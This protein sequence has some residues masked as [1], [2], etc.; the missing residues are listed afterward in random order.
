MMKIATVA[1][2]LLVLAV[3]AAAP[4]EAISTAC[5]PGGLP[6]TTTPP[7]ASKDLAHGFGA[8]LDRYHIDVWRVPCQ[9]GSGDVALLLRATPITAGPFV[10][11]VHFQI[12]QG[13]QIDVSFR[14]T[15]GGLSFCNDLLVGRHDVQLGAYLLLRP[16]VR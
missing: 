15:P 2:A 12:L 16:R 7:V 14:Q 1:F 5:L 6:P 4:A 13:A 8:S 9:D 3:T 10:C 11:S